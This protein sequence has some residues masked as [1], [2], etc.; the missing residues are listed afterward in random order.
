MQRVRVCV[1]VRADVGEYLFMCRVLCLCAVNGHLCIMHAA[2]DEQTPNHVSLHVSSC[3]CILSL[4]ISA[5]LVLRLSLALFKY[6]K[7]KLL[8]RGRE[9]LLYCLV[10]GMN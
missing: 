2:C 6:M 7:Y 4:L 3:E 10:L 5:P 9:M 8:K 1:F